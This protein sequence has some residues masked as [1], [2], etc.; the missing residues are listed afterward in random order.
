MSKTQ[1]SSADEVL[2]NLDGLLPDLEALYKDVHSHPE[3]SMQETR[4]AGLAADRLRA[5]GYEVTTGVG[6]TG[7]VGVLRNG[8]GP[9]VMLRAD[10][11]ALP[12]EEATGLPY[13]SKATATDRQGK[14]VPVAHM[15]GHDM[16]VT[17]L[18]G[19]TKLLADARSTWRGTLMAVFQPGEETAEGAQ[20]M[21]DDGLFK[22][23]PQPTAVLGQ[24]VMVGP[25]GTVAGRTGAITSAADSWQI[26]LFGRGAHGSMP[27]ASIDPVV[28]AAATVMRL[29]TIVARE[30][31]AA[32]SAVVTVGALQAG[33]KENVIPDEAIIKL[34]V[35]TFDAGV[36]KRVLAAIER[37]V[38]AEAEASGAPRRPEIT[39]LDHYPLNVNDQ[40]VSKRVVENFRG[41]F[42]ADRVRETGPAPASE[43]FGSFGSE[44]HSPS[45][46][47]FVGGTD[48]DVYSKAKE[49]GRLNELPVNHSP[50]FAPVLHPTL[51]TGVEALVVATRAWL[52]A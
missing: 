9:T 23:F 51:R 18:A 49:A 1:E 19:A 10:M 15:C 14:T 24:H 40:A 16:H 52:T 38:N 17:W 5:A 4:T 45:A 35:R 50:K 34:N 2:R 21:I 20:A 36:R 46:F 33:T 27:Q 6:R 44:W 11:D 8:D 37:I 29:Q 26:R 13:A 3:L 25:S 43:D 31:A 42:G 7:V 22:R 28:M 32:E 39:T 30:V 12:I 48:P 41:Y 47:W